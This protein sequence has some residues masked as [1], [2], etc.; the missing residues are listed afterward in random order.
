MKKKEKLIHL[1]LIVLAGFVFGA[2]KAQPQ[3]SY[4]N[5]NFNITVPAIEY[6]EL[7]G[8]KTYTKAFVE[9]GTGA[10]FILKTEDNQ[11]APL[12]QQ[13]YFNR[14][15]NWKSIV[16]L[17]TYYDTIR[18]PP[19]NT[20][21]VI[22]I[23]SGVARE[24]MLQPPMPDN[25]Y[26][27]IT[28]AINN[29]V[30]PSETITLGIT[31]KNIPYTEPDDASPYN[32]SII[33]LFYNN[34][35]NQYLFQPIPSA[36]NVTYSFNGNPV[37][38]I[39]L[40]NEETILSDLSG[41]PGP[42]VELINRANTNND[43]NNVL[44]IKPKYD[45]SAPERNIFISMLSSP[46]SAIIPENSASYKAFIIDYNSVNGNAS[47]DEFLQSM[48]A[49]LSSH[50]PN[51]ILTT[52]S[53]FDS[54]H[55]ANNRRVD[56]EIQF[57]NDG[58]KNAEYIQVKA[59]IPNGIKFPTNGTNL[60]KCTL[61]KDTLYLY[62]QGDP[63]FFPSK[64]TRYGTYKLDEAARMITFT[65]VNAHL[66]YRGGWYDKNNVGLIKFSLRTNPGGVIPNCLAS[67]VSIVFD[68]NPAVIDDCI[69]RVNCSIK[70]PP[71]KFNFKTKN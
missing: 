4:G 64:N 43:Y 48:E 41:V 63:V 11:L 40:H 45:A 31:Y 16:Q 3:I 26:V 32:S 52:P 50:D 54:T 18:R 51:H 39:R 57:V 2:A 28:N 70:C 61:G 12:S 8:H 56:Y 37:E 67:G 59:I 6:A 69:T 20:S 35:D 29:Q 38:P 66:S 24:N 21:S 17:T 34:S 19:L 62:K 25:S 36:A 55:P 53:C 42:V 13:W 65:I 60:F 44:Y 68:K 33:A 71:K 10:F 27:T 47:H 14:P 7:D 30:L 1:S 15:G 49:D 22:Q 9:T 58:K 23:N 5:N 46:L